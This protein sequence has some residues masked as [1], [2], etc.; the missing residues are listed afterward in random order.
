MAFSRVGDLEGQVVW[1]RS[2]VDVLKEI[3]LLKV[4]PDTYEKTYY[5]KLGE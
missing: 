5:R 3:H 2:W 1:W 4:N